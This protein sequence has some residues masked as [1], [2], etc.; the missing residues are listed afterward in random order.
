MF[1][2]RFV[3]VIS[4]IFC[5]VGPVNAGKTYQFDFQK[6]IEIDG[7]LELTINNTNGNIIITANNESQLKV[8]AI[9]KIYAD[10]KQEA[11]LVADHIQIS[12][13]RTDGH[14]MVEPQFSRIA[15]RS[16]SFWQKLFGKSGEQS[17][18][19]LDFTISVPTD[20]NI[21]IYNNNGDVEVGGLR[22]RIMVSGSVGD[23][24]IHD[25]QGEIEV[26]T[27]SGQVNLNDIE[28]KVR[29]IANGS[30]IDFY[31]LI[32]DLEIR[33]S[34]GV[35]KGEYLTGDLIL[36]Q[37]GGDITLTHIEGDI[38]GKSKTGKFRI[39]QDYGALDLST[40]SGDI[41]VR[42]ELN[43]DKNY[44]VETISGS[45]RFLIPEAS[46]GKIR[47]EA[48]SGNIDT[49]IPIS[50]DSFTRTRISGS[51]GTDGPKVVLTTASGAITLMEF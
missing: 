15:S 43:S 46:G 3:I 42:T 48:G 12:I 40:E 34:S 35:I 41:E 5:M 27:T 10:D 36:N 19:S 4:L 7:P 31:S 23:I 16:Q 32:G 13:L 2:V 49:K 33:N 38:R 20:C 24:N 37:V 14:F 26:S 47:M 8:E 9:K 28:G 22:G 6:I 39:I 25:I 1:A 11:E 50:I 45:I 17:Y 21:D 29:I 51:F 30:D 18:G 44:F